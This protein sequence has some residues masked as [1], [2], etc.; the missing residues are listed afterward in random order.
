[1][2]QQGSPIVLNVQTREGVVLKKGDEAVVVDEGQQ[3]T[4]IVAPFEGE[5]SI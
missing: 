3:G 2:S 1:L 5:K 4:Y